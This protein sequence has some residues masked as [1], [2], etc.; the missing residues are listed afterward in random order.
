MILAT[1]V[2]AGGCFWGVQDAFDHVSGVISTQA[3]Y[4]GGTKEN[5]SYHQVCSGKTGH[6]EAVEI[7]YNPQEVTL[8]QLLDVFFKIHDPTTLNRQGPD[9]G[10]QYRSAIFYSTAEEKKEALAKIKQLE[11]ERRFKNPIVTEIVPF[12]FFYPA[13]E[14]HQKYIEKHKNHSCGIR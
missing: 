2:L 14:Y 1:L 10:T 11:K 4:T 13:E 3:G 6:A 5:P 12:Q 7:V 8:E 9:V